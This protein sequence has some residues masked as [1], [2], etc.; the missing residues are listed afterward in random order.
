MKERFYR[1]YNEGDIVNF[2]KLKTPLGIGRIVY[3]KHILS[4]SEN[5]HSQYVIDDG[6][7]LY[8][9]YEDWISKITE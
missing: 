2:L 6:E 8:I 5:D 3:I 1:M 7:K 9:V 4:D